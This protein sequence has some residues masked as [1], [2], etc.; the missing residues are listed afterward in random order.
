MH[1]DYP[2]NNFQKHWFQFLLGIT[3]IPRGGG[4]GGGGGGVINVHLGL[5]VHVCV[6][7]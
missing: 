5:H 3:V 1:F 2:Q 7:L 6:K 4:G